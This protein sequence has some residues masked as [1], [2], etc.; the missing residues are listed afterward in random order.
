MFACSCSEDSLKIGSSPASPS[1]GFRRGL[2]DQGSMVQLRSSSLRGMALEERKFVNT[3]VATGGGGDLLML[4]TSAGRQKRE[5]KMPSR[6][7]DTDAFDASGVIDISKCD[8]QELIDGDSDVGER[9][10]VPAIE[11]RQAKRLKVE[12]LK[13]ETIKK[14]TVLLP[15]IDLPETVQPWCMYH[16]QHSCPC[17]KFRNPLDFGPDL[18][19][20]RN[21]AKRTLG[22]NFK[23]AK[24]ESVDASSE[25]PQ[26]AKRTLGKPGQAPLVRSNSTPAGSTPSAAITPGITAASKPSPPTRS[27]KFSTEHHCARTA[28]LVLKPRHKTQLPHKV[29]VV[30]KKEENPATETAAHVLSNRSLANSAGVRPLVS[31]VPAIPFQQRKQPQQQQRKI[32]K[33]MND[34]FDLSMKTKGEVQYI[35]WN[36]FR[37]KFELKQ[38]TIWCLHRGGRNLLFVTRFGEA[39]YAKEA[40]D[41]RTSHALGVAVQ[42]PPIIQSLI[43]GKDKGVSHHDKY[44]ILTSNG[45]G[46][47]ISGCLKKKEASVAVAGKTAPAKQESVDASSEKPQVAIRTLGAP[48]RTHLEQSNCT[49]GSTPSAA[50]TPG[51]T[52][53]SKPSPPTS[54]NELPQVKQDT[55]SLPLPKPVQ[56]K[57]EAVPQ[58]PRSRLSSEPSSIVQLEDPSTK[59][60]C[61]KNLV[62]MTRDGQA[63]M[64]IKLPTTTPQ[65]YWST[66]KVVII[67][68]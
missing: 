50:I 19:A 62:T 39:F 21:V 51:I 16:C 4:G 68:L 52:A 31:Q 63:V 5:R 27:Y 11:E 17:S 65:Q 46:W 9:I 59:L 18:T 7:Q 14:C 48:G 25:K 60:K 61:G 34:L 53:A 66:I 33:T 15:R 37:A 32:V 23:T 1:D 45:I 26:V 38:I 49:P 24:R 6:Y 64:Q 56:I 29:V 47:E 67:I 55:P 22:G 57:N 30:S 58:R 10:A 28:G 8:D 13:E 54:S 44:A 2:T 41:L 42:L 36:V 35:W 20:S 43:S 12:H 40:F 3:V